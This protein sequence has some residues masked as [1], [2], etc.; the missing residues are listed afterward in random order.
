[1]IFIVKDG[2]FIVVSVIMDLQHVEYLKIRSPLTVASDWPSGGVEESS[3]L[4][5]LLQLLKATRSL[6]F[7]GMLNFCVRLRF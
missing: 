3:L 5:S 7:L 1:M 4:E 2:V 6:H